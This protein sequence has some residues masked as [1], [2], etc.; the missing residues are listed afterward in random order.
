VCC[1]QDFSLEGAARADLR[2][3]WR[4]AERDGASF[5]VILP[6]R[7][8]EV[9]PELRRISDFVADA[10]IGRRKALFRWVLSRQPI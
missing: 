3:A 8:A 4:R 10:Q 2:Q 1:W 5:E 9:L 6:E 7:I